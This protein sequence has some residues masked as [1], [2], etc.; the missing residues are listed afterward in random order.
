MVWSLLAAGVGL[1]AA[2]PFYGPAPTNI[3]SVVSTKAAV[4]AI[5]A[6]KDAR[7][8]GSRPQAE[9]A[10][11][12]AG[13]PYQINVYNGVDHAF[14]NDTNSARYGPEQAQLAW[15]ATIGWFRKYLV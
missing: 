4:L 12:S 14:H 11:K 7:V 6:E 13:V 1:K 15:T 3:D 9:T 2:V 10:L 8:N 5:Y